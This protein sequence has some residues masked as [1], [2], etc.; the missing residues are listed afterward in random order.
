MKHAMDEFNRLMGELQRMTQGESEDVVIPVLTA[1]LAACG[2][3]SMKS[4]DLYK[5]FVCEQIDAA[6]D[7]FQ[8]RK[9]Q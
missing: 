6:Y 5:R 9:Q 1:F 8:R 4:R 2:P 3:F 7:D